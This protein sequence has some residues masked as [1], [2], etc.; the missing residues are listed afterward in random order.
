VV[1]H[2]W[3]ETRQE[4]D[5]DICN[6]VMHHL[7]RPLED[8]EDEPEDSPQAVLQ[9]SE[10]GVSDRLETSSYVHILRSL[11]VPSFVFQP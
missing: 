1:F 6:I 7:N 3:Q 11:F 8:E 5:A 10:G 2:W 4:N 9:I